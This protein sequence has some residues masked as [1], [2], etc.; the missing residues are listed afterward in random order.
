[1][2]PGNSAVA[3][4]VARL[5]S[6]YTTAINATS[7]GLPSRVVELPAPADQMVLSGL[8]LY[9]L[10]RANSRVLKYL[11]NADGTAIQASASP[12]LVQQGDQIGAATVGQLTLMTWMPPG[13]PRAQPALLVLDR[14]GSLVEYNPTEGLTRLALRDPAAWADATAIAGY[15]GNLY[16]LSASNGTLSWLPLQAS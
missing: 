6:E 7:L 4:S 1:D 3:T 11:L 14:A 5:R 9:V 12:V 16:A 13:G 8:D 2:Q 10:D 15:A